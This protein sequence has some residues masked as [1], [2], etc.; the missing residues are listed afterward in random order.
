[1]ARWLI[2]DAR[3]RKAGNRGVL[4]GNHKLRWWDAEDR[5][6]DIAWRSVRLERDNCAYRAG[7]RFRSRTKQPSTPDMHR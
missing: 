3:D 5:E 1:M 2:K 6:R 7:K 4:P